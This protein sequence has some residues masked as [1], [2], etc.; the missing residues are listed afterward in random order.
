M[1]IELIYGKGLLK[2]DIPEENVSAVYRKTKMPPVMDPDRAVSDSLANPIGSKRLGEIA[3]PGDSVCIV[4]NDITRPVPN[5]LILPHIIGELTGAGVGKQDIFILNAT[6][7]HRPN[8]EAEIVELVGEE[9]AASFRFEN[10]D[11]FNDDEHMYAGT[12]KDG[13]EVFL[14]RRYMQAD[15]KILTGL[16]EPHFMAGYSGGRKALCPGCASIRTIHRIHSPRFMEDENA[17]N[18]ELFS[19]P[20]HLELLEICG[21]AGVDFIVNVVIDEKRELCGVFSGHYDR[22]H[23]EGV[24]FVRQFDEIPAAESVEIVITSSAGYPLDKTYYQTVKGMVGAL[25]LV[26]TG[27]TIII[28]SE[29][30][31]GMGNDTFVKCLRKLSEFDDLDEYVQY[32]SVYHNFVPDQWQAEKLAESL[33]KAEIMLVTNGI[34]EKDLP[35]THATPMKTVEEAVARALHIHG[36][37]ARIAVIPEGPY[38]IPTIAK[39]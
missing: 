17:T 36:P 23:I 2:A 7:T 27:G 12:T 16:I 4:I 10:H 6:G 5:K 33:R 13:T 21:M 3:G 19:N 8:L 26:K 31:E 39:R 35:L 15:V 25:N 29:C 14:D 1:E 38:V 11:A 37:Q 20:L 28:A 22:A 30:S 9:I 24:K 34:P 18:C 32:L